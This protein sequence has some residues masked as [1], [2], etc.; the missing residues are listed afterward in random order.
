MSILKRRHFPVEV[1]LLW[2]RRYQGNSSG[3]WRV[4]ET[5]VRV[6]GQW[7]YLFRA[8]D[9]YVQLLIDLMPLDCQIYVP[10]F[11]WAKRGVRRANGRPVRS[12]IS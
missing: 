3:S 7:K 10:I 9:K 1:I 5:Y 2:V 8:I 6:E 11:H 4:E 12:P